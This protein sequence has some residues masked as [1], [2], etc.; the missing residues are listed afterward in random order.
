MSQSLAMLPFQGVKM[1][2]GYHKPSPLGRAMVCCPVGAECFW[3]ALC[4]QPAG[5]G[6]GMLPRWGEMFLD[7]I[8]YPA[9]WAGLWYA[10]PL[11]RMS[12]GPKGQYTIAPGIA[13]G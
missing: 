7:G 4:T 5:P 8:V 6:Y 13:R 12:R 2:C 10:A 11:G 9:R 1:F 3:M